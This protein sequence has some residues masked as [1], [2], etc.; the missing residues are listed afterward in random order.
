MKK[1]L[2]KCCI[3]IIIHISFHNSVV[4]FEGLSRVPYKKF[5]ML[6]KLNAHVYEYI[7]L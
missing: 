5:T 4:N 3:H 7:Y 2:V 6:E 1:K